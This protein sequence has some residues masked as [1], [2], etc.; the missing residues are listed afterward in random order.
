MSTQMGHPVWVLIWVIIKINEQTVFPSILA[1]QRRFNSNCM[2]LSCHVRVSEWIHTFQTRT[3]NQLVR[4][5]TLKH[6]AKLTKTLKIVRP[7]WLNGYVFIYEL[8]GC[9]TSPVAV[10]FQLVTNF[11]YTAVVLFETTVNFLRF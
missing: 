11:I 6:L 7:V 5:R 3:H 8:S 1:S 10:T 2:F 9:G 4:E